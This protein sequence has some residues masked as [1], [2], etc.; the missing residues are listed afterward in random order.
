MEAK[1]GLSCNQWIK[2]I[3]APLIHLLSLPALIQHP[4]TLFAT[5]HNIITMESNVITWLVHHQMGNH[6]WVVIVGGARF[7]YPNA[8]NET[9]HAPSGWNRILEKERLQWLVTFLATSNSRKATHVE[10][11]KQNFCGLENML[12][13][14][15]KQTKSSYINQPVLK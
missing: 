14:K 4:Q 15:G 6:R 1:S 10:N 7:L 11:Q 8:H 2:P 5:I 9:K 12:L 13:D 3:M